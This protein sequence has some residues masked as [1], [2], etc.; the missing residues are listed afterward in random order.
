[1]ALKTGTVAQSQTEY[2]EVLWGLEDWEIEKK[3]KNPD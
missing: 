3:E 2:V 1:M